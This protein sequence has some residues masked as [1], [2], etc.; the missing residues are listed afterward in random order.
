[1]KSVV[2]VL[3]TALVATV[4]FSVWHTQ[5]IQ[6]Q[7]QR[8][9]HYADSVIVARGDTISKLKQQRDSLLIVAASSR[10]YYVTQWK[11]KWDT[12]KIEIHSPE[13]TLPQA[14]AL[15]ETADSTIEACSVALL[16]CGRAQ[17][18]SL[19][20]ERQDSLLL[21][22]LRYRLKLEQNKPTGS[23]LATKLL[24]A[25]GGMAVMGTV[26]VATR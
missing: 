24:W 6:K 20:K 14:V 13:L 2:A 18:A 15:L 19:T 7:F 17:Q 16:D 10:T 4:A 12:L 9:E 22:D 21:Q 11:T 1:M 3:G 8:A 26:C 23:S 5:V 25:M